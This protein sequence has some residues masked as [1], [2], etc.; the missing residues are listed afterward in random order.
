MSDDFLHR[1]RAR[2]RPEF[3]ARL[4]QKL[5]GQPVHSRARLIRSLAAGLLVGA[6]A[7]AI[8]SFALHG[9]FAGFHWSG[10]GRGPAGSQAVGAQAR[11]GPAA[12]QAPRTVDGAWPQN[13]WAV[14][15]PSASGKPP[16]REAAGGSLVVPIPQGSTS[17][18]N[19]TAAQ[20][21]SGAA[22]IV[23]PNAEPLRI[24]A[25]R[26]ISDLTDM[27]VQNFVKS[28]FKRPQ[29]SVVTAA[30]LF[31]D[32]C[33]ASSADFAIVTRRMT[34]TEA[35]TCVRA[36]TGS[37]V[38]VKLGAEAVVLVR[39]KLYGPLPLSARDVYLALAKAAPD[40]ANPAVLMANRRVNWGEVDSALPPDY[41]QVF[42]PELASQLGQRFLSLVMD[43]GCDPFPSMTAVQKP[44]DRDAA[45]RTVREGVYFDMNPA[46]Y[47][48]F[49]QRLLM[50][51]NAVGVM[52][53]PG[54]Q[55]SGDALVVCPLGGVQPT[56][57]SIADGSYPGA[58]TVYLYV[59][60][61]RFQR[62]HSTGAFLT[63]TLGSLFTPDGFVRPSREESR[64][65]LDK[66][67][68]ALGS[69]P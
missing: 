34:A 21:S 18:P 47:P 13:P 63:M 23:S 40:P 32:L 8:A 9:E 66:A 25:T 61:L 43:A 38:E 39:S 41:I 26:E 3:L 17:A 53:Y 48:M 12:A 44:A 22:L 45:C 30:E 57:E 20:Y 14:A 60:R 54:Y 37:P 51:P 64:E 28:G 65:T 56:S 6:S 11:E 52:G 19:G 67:L 15:T 69:Q 36:G 29:V 58:R 35:D 59:N 33:S 24:T 31:A 49:V 27:S 1:L 55:M 7:L 5:D 2:P 62:M 68:A 50:Y 4:K 46:L 42:G 10:L 16:K